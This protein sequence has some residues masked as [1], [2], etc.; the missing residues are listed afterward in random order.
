MVARCYIAGA[1]DFF[2]G[3]L[4]RKGDYIIA[5][6]GGYVELVARGY[7]PDIVVGDFDSLGGIPQHNNVL[8]S[9]TE[10]DDTDMMLAVKHGLERGCTEF[11]INGGLGG[12]F[13][14]TLAN[15]QV[16]SY[17]SRS[18]AQGVLVGRDVCITSVSNG[19]ISFMTGASGRV[20]V[21]CAGDKAEGV[22]LSGM[23]YTLD[24]ARLTLDDPLGVS[25]EFTGAPAVIT[26]RKGTLLVVWTDGL[27]MLDGDI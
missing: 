3:E 2:S 18:K 8:S 17:I 13:D 4:P 21:F 25:N 27:D 1:G 19:S 23:K 16:L 14:H 24:E 22:T 26:V 12:R 9:P 7:K 15:L 11:I 5:A 6:D 20:S 10:K